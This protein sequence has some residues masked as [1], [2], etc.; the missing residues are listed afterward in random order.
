MSAFSAAASEEDG[1]TIK[2][3]RAAI[4]QA[5]DWIA[6]H[7][8]LRPISA[9]RMVGVL[10]NAMAAAPQPPVVEQEPRYLDGG[11]RYKV[12][13]L[14]SSGYCIAGLPSEMLGQWVALVDATDNKHMTRQQ[15]RQPLTPEAVN[16]L[17]I[18]HARSGAYIHAFAQAIER[19]HNVGGEA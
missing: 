14:K 6:E 2:A 16:D 12:T 8:D 18:K 7:P 3:L 9:G 10:A 5:I 13:H 1:D 4:Q 11:A 15:P 17:W 19:A